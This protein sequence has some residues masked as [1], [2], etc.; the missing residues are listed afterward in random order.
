[1]LSVALWDPWCASQHPCCD[2]TQHAVI[3]SC[4]ILW[5][6]LPH[7]SVESVKSVHINKGKYEEAVL[8]HC[9]YP[10]QN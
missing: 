5:Q 7:K 8:M 6:H 2:F 3:L 10:Y 1:M 4:R 9:S